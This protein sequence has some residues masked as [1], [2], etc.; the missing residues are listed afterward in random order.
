MARPGLR[1]VVLLNRQGPVGGRNRASAIEKTSRSRFGTDPLQVRER[2]A[3][4][5]RDLLHGQFGHQVVNV[6]E[7]LLLGRHA[8]GEEAWACYASTSPYA[9]LSTWSACYAAR[10][11]DSRRAGSD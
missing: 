7:G 1:G 6:D 10:P 4:V 11:G 9:K 8:S 3:V 5:R 2:H